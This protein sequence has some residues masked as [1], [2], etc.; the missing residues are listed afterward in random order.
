MRAVGGVTIAQEE[1]LAQVEARVRSTGAAAGFTTAELADMAGELQQVTAFGD[2]A[3]LSMQGLLLSFRSITGDQFEAA[4]EAALDLSV[5]VQQDLRSAFIQLGKAL[6][7]PITGLDG[8]SKSGT[9][10]TPVQQQVIRALAESGRVAEAQALILQELQTQYGGAARAAR[11]T[12]GG[13]LEALG[14]AFGDLFELQKSSTSGIRGT[15]ESL[16]A[17]LE[18]IDIAE[19]HDDFGRISDAALVLAG[20]FVGRLV[21]SMAK[22]AAAQLHLT[23]ASRAGVTALTATGKAARFAAGGLRALAG[24]GGLLLLGAY[25]AVE[26]ARGNRE[27]ESSLDHLPE[28][29]TA[30][31]KSIERLSTAQLYRDVLRPLAA[32]IEEAEA[33]L[34]SARRKQ[35]DAADGVLGGP[36]RLPREFVAPVG[37]GAVVVRLPQREVTTDLANDIQAG[38]DDAEQ[39]LA[40]LRERRTTA[41]ELLGTLRA[42]PVATGEQA[43]PEQDTSKEFAAL[44]A[45]LATE[46]EKANRV[47]SARQQLIEQN[48]AAE[49]DL[50]ETL[51]GR[52]EAERDA[53]LA[54]IGQREEAATGEPALRVLR[55]RI[56]EVTAAVDFSARALERQAARSR[57]L[58]EVQEA[59]PAA[60]EEVVR[61]L[62]EERVA[63]D[64]A[65]RALRLSS[66]AFEAVTGGAAG[67]AEQLRAL[68]DLERALPEGAIDDR[69]LEARRR[70]LEREAARAAL[71]DRTDAAAGKERFLLTIQEQA[72]DSAGAVEAVL[73]NAFEGASDALAEFVVTGKLNFSDL[74]NSIIRDLI[75]IAI[76]R[77]IVGAFTSAFG[78]LGQ[79]G[80]AR[81]FPTT[82]GPVAGSPGLYA[83]HG[84]GVAGLLRGRRSGVLAEAIGGAQRLHGGGVAGLRSDEVPTV[85][86]RGEVVFTPEQARALGPTPEV[87]INIINRGTA[88]T[89]TRREQRVDG[90]K[91]IIDIVLDDITRGGPIAQAVSQQAALG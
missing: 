5:G 51:R 58:I 26:F 85:L 90:R 1:A 30:Y 32:Q 35:D 86:R 16:I 28:S 91:M 40:Q 12:L 43:P 71:G 67:Y 70:N 11:D 69:A 21:V 52:A 61:S 50:R 23:R 60:S 64:Q 6:D 82:P 87:E 83:A 74:A 45:D 56:A 63:L 44:Q 79:T 77:V 18:E 29:I 84:G 76:Q 55:E 3:I 59:Y 66:E 19:L 75:R 73:T 57:I 34:A 25:A 14:N 54:A 8:L 65:E 4:T 68:I 41:R 27:V 72:E 13:A 24:P 80:G 33:R 48:T 78:G 10:F 47:F 42:G 2:E 15:L 49:S 88:Q 31:R 89:V 37:F 22:A 17:T 39:K 38:I 62:V 20:I 81:A 7:D 53:T 36:P 9:K 46:T